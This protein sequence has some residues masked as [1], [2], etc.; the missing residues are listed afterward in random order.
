MPQV[1][2]ILN[3]KG[4]V[5]KTT[6][7]THLAH[8]LKRAA[9]NVLLVD[10]D[11]QG[12]ARDW[13]EANQGQVLPVVGLDRETLPTDLAAISGSYD[14]VVIDGAPQIAR[15]AAAAIKCADLVLIPVQPSPFDIWATADLVEL[16]KTRQVMT[17][18]K[19]KAVFVISRAI[20]NTRLSQEVNEALEG[21]E[22]A[23]LKHGTSQRV[24]YPTVAS[25]GQ[26]VFNESGNPAIA[27]IEA[28][29]QEV[30][31]LLA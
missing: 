13:N 16:I 14:Y 12:S 19:P 4:G 15:L 6:L 18:G 21:Y 22:L 8:A 17:E 20:K 2:A 23:I 24:I 7:A 31:E 10:S 28:L 26:T 5:G 9:F 11:P 3:Q 30:L 29:A 27:E 1:I 25:K